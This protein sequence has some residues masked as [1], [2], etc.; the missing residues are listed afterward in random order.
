MR[1][2]SCQAFDHGVGGLRRPANAD[3]TLPYLEPY[4]TGIGLWNALRIHPTLG[5]AI[6][7]MSKHLYLALRRLQQ[8]CRAGLEP[9]S[10]IRADPGE[11]EEIR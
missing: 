6:L 3:H 4:G 10:A 9:R 1:D 7:G 8:F 11:G 2:C 5:I